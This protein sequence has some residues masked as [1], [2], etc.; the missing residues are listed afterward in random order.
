MKNNKT[1]TPVAITAF[2]H[3]QLHEQSSLITQ[4]LRPQKPTH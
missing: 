1:W 3:I 4:P 2:L